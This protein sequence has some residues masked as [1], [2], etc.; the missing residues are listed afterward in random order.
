M[1]ID[2]STLIFCLKTQ[3]CSHFYCSDSCIVADIL[4]FISKIFLEAYRI[5]IEAKT[6]FMYHILYVKYKLVNLQY[7]IHIIFFYTKT[8]R[9]FSESHAFTLPMRM[10]DHKLSSHWGF[11]SHLC[12]SDLSNN[13]EE[14]ESLLMR[15]IARLLQQSPNEGNLSFNQTQRTYREA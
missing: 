15:W 4:L 8:L 6:Y 1:H 7:T 9:I 13:T 3:Q 12:N 5:F 14:N 11:M 2:I 10:F